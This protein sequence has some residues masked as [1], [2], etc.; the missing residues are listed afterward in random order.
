MN[1]VSQ[2]AKDFFTNGFFVIFVIPVVILL[3]LLSLC[4]IYNF[5]ILPE[6]LKSR[7]TP[8][9]FKFPK[10]SRKKTGKLYKWEAE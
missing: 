6:D 3:V 4:K 7:K 5:S 1:F 8:P 9:K 10:L 2:H